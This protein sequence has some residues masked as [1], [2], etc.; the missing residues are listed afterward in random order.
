MAFISERFFFLWNDCDEFGD[1]ERLQLVLD[2]I[3]DERLMQTLSRIRGKGRNDNP[4]RA[5]WNSV[6]AGIVFDH[7]SVESLIRELNRNALLRELCGFNPL[8]GSAAIPSSSAYSRFLVGLFNQEEQMDEIFNSL[9]FS[10]HEILPSFCKD[11]AFDGKSIPSL[12]TRTPKDKPETADRRRDDDGDWGVKRYQ[13]LRGDG[14]VW[15]KVKSWFGYRLHLIVDANYELP[16]AFEVTKASSG[17][18]PVIRNM[19]DEL[20]VEH[21]KLVENCDHGMGDKGYDSAETV[22]KLWDDYKIKPIID[23]KNMWKDGEETRLLQCKDIEN[24][25]YDYKGTVF[26]HCPTTGEVRKM[27]YGGF[28]SDREALK[29]HCPV[30]HYGID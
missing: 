3:P 5:T 27:S 30:K 10:L 11:I 6:L 14:T 21:P 25:T 4:I 23:I 13:G 18:Q 9:V 1:L 19:F 26:C 22:S 24:V 20:S 29:Y 15:E 28:E 16:V 17:E 2:N 7:T 12:S 8:L